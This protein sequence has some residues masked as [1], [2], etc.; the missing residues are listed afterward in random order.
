MSLFKEPL[1]NGIIFTPV[2]KNQE[3]QCFDNR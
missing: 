3:K 1:F 2:F